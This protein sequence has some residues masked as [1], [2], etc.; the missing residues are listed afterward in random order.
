MAAV[1]ALLVKPLLLSKIGLVT[2]T[3]RSMHL[4][5]STLQAAHVT[6]EREARALKRLA[7]LEAMFEDS[8]VMDR[9]MS[10]GR[11]LRLCNAIAWASENVERASR[12][13][14]GDLR[15]N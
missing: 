15:L 11:Y 8:S 14:T 3:G 10:Q 4:Q 1:P 5:H 7:R 2:R 13:P 9:L 12:A 6:S